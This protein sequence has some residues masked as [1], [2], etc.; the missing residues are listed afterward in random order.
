MYTARQ[1]GTEYR[2]EIGDKGKAARLPPVIT[3]SRNSLL[4]RLP[5][6][7]HPEFNILKYT[8]NTCET[9]VRRL[10]EGTDIQGCKEQRPVAGLYIL[11]FPQSL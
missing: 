10:V 11:T 1:H 9:K 4:S 5:R 6:F 3:P 2:G 8:I 7:V